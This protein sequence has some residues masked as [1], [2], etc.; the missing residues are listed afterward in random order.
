MVNEILYFGISWII[1]TAFGV[2]SGYG[3]IKYRVGILEARQK[4][5]LDE[6]KKDVVH[7]KDCRTCKENILLKARITELERVGSD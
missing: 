5:V 7:F 3:L 1:S 2:L 4:D 6:L